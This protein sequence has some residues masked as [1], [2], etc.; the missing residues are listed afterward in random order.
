MTILKVY[1]GTVWATALGKV[2]NG[3][4][5]VEK[6]NFHNGSAFV[7]LYALG[8]VTLS[9]ELMSSTNT[10]LTAH[11]G[12]A[13]NP[14][15]SI[16]EIGPDTTDRV[17][18]DA[19]EWWSDEPEASIG[20][21]YDV[22]CASINSGVWDFQAASVGTWIQI[23]IARDW[24]VTVLTMDAPDQQV[25]NANFEISLTGGASAIDSAIYEGDANN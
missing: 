20:D 11:S 9:G 21:D 23:S 17:Q 25:C 19:T 12:P 24:R 6:M 13:F 3:S 8:F 22:R 10:N 4:A 18:V 2:Y 7:E 15:G 16:D 14:D 1:S 5:W